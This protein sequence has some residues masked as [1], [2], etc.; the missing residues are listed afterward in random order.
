M[1]KEYKGIKFY[2]TPYNGYFVS[3]CGIII[4]YRKQASKSNGRVDYS[5][6]PKRLSYKTDKDGYFEIVFSIDGK[7]YYKKVHQ[8]VA[9]TF[10][11]NFNKDLVVDHINRNRKDNRSKNLRW[12]SKSKNSDG[13]KGKK[14]YV[15]KQAMVGDKIFG[16]IKDACEFANV[17]YWYY[18]RHY[19]KF[20]HIIYCGVE[21]IIIVSRADIETAR[22]APHT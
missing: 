16:S 17:P 15:C 5:K 13:Q 6:E 22:S 9:E 7:R 1:I 14:T 8:V 12:L 4:S 19:K 10:L 11:T 20:K 21:T 3:R 18:A 2:Q